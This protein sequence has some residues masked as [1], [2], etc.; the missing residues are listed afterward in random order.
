VLAFLA[1]L[2]PLACC[3]GDE[4]RDRYLRRAQSVYPEF[5]EESDR[6]RF[7]DEREYER[8]VRYDDGKEVGPDGY[9]RREYVEEEDRRIDS[10]P[11]EREDFVEEKIT[12]KRVSVLL[13]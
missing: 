8:D 6:A 1:P 10:S 5:V 2:E 7:E 11:R 4:I 13:S 9:L 12:E 3:D